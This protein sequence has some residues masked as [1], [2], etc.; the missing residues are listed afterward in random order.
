MNTETT[1]VWTGFK[2]CE[3]KVDKPIILVEPLEP[4]GDPQVWVQW[5]GKSDRAELKNMQ[6][7]FPVPV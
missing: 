3:K 6:F 2:P 4:G 1:K 5:Y 7:R